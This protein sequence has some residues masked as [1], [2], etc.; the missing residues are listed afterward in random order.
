MKKENVTRRVYRTLIVVVIILIEMEEYVVCTRLHYKVPQHNIAQRLQSSWE[1]RKTLVVQRAVSLNIRMLLIC[2]THHLIVSLTVNLIL[3][4]H[5]DTRYFTGVQNFGQCKRKC[6]RDECYGF[7]YD[8]VEKSCD[9]FMF[10]DADFGVRCD[11]KLSMV[12]FLKCPCFSSDEVENAASDMIRGTTTSNLEKTS[13]QRTSEGSYGLH[14]TNDVT[15]PADRIFNSFSVGGRD[16]NQVGTCTKDNNLEYIAREEKD[17]CLSQLQNSCNT[18]DD[19]KV[20]LDGK[21]PCYNEDDLNTAVASIN[22]GLKKLRDEA[23]KRTR[24]SSISFFYE[25]TFN[26]APVEGYGVYTSQRSRKCT[27]AGDMRL[28]NISAQS[29]IHCSRLIEKAC[30]QL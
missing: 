26:N 24:G 15:L 3:I 12:E 29:A 2:C 20:S 17:I 28:Q 9:V 30:D 4:Y 8:N 18:L 25:H 27:F 11:K 19:K 5:I 23:C 1:R 13:C 22:D 10:G 7:E 16:L 6:E 14:Y 21:C